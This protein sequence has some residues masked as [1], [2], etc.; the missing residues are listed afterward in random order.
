MAGHGSERRSA[1][2]SFLDQPQTDDALSGSGRQIDEAIV[3]PTTEST[4]A[5]GGVTSS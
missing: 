5:A 2:P 3:A 1:A 4:V